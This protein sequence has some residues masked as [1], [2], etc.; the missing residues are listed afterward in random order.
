[1]SNIESLLTIKRLEKYQNKSSLSTIEF[2]NYNIQLCESLYP[3]FNYLEIVLRN[4]VDKVLSIQIDEDWLF[5][6]SNF[7]NYGKS[8]LKKAKNKLIKA[9]KPINKDY[10]ISELNLGFWT[11]LF[12]KDY[13]NLIWQKFPMSLQEIFNGAKVYNNKRVITN[14]KVIR[15]YRNRVFHHGFILQ[16]IK[17]ETSRSVHDKIYTIL[18]LIDANSALI[19]LKKIDRFLEI[20]QI[21][22]ENG[23]IPKIFS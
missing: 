9:H 8:E 3:A 13:N 23:A 14:L 4:K 17:G 19:E 12:M 7:T 10:L 11:S 16:A 6:D 22:R 1:M 20:Y 21:G 5:D 2:Y 15:E 18:K